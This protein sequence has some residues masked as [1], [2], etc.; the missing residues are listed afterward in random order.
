MDIATYLVNKFLDAMF[1]V[2]LFITDTIF[3]LIGK[4][5]G[6]EMSSDS[7]L[8]RVLYWFVF[9]VVFVILLFVLLSILIGQPV[10]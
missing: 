9:L 10:S 6:A 5:V 1:S 3:V 4:F 8:Y 2:S 7:C